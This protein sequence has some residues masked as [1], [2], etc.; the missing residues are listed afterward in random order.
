MP[1]FDVRVGGRSLHRDGYHLSF[2]Y[3]R[4][5]AAAVW[6]QALGLGN[7]AENTFMPSVEGEDDE[8]LYAIIRRTVAE[9]VKPI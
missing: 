1:E 9:N 5:A 3:G 6:Y 4:F 7:I 8:T 2:G